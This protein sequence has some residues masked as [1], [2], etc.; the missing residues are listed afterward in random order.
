MSRHITPDTQ[1]NLRHYAPGVI[2][3]LSPR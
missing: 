1:F 3:H 2:K